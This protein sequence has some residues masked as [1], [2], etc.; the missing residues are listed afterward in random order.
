MGDWITT[1]LGGSF[2][3]I[4]PPEFIAVVVNILPAD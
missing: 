1:A 3:E 4:V 2:V